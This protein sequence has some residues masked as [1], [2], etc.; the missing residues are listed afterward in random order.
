M[1]KNIN[2]MEE[3][4]TSKQYDNW[5]GIYDLTFGKL[6]R[7]RVKRSIQEL[8]LKPGQTVLDIGIGTGVSIGHYPEGTNVVGMDI[9]AG[10]LKQARQQARK[11]VSW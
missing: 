2:E 5:S 7:K 4:R 9:S 10:M 1:I 3:E 11:L 8:Q 6:V